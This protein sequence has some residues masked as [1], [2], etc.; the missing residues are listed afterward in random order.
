MYTS[1]N[2]DESLSMRWRVA[3]ECSK[4]L[5]T[6]HKNRGKTFNCLLTWQKEGVRKG[7]QYDCV[8]YIH[9][10]L[11][12]TASQIIP[13]RLEHE[14]SPRPQHCFIWNRSS[15]SSS[16]LSSCNVNVHREDL[17]SGYDCAYVAKIVLEETTTPNLAGISGKTLYFGYLSLSSKPKKIIG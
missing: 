11:G 9:T 1:K 4:D 16:D 2:Q 13:P 10:H 5:S 12:R 3:G 8:F 14:V 15:S 6:K 17:F 7:Y